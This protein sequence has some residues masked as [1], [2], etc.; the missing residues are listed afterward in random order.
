MPGINATGRI[1]N[2]KVEDDEQ[3]CNDYIGLPL[4]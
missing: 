2:V 3:Y 1:P 4:A